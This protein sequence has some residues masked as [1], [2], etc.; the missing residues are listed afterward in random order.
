MEVKNGITYAFFSWLWK[1]KKGFIRFFASR[2]SINF[3]KCY[4]TH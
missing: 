2:K 3:S 1:N 4:N